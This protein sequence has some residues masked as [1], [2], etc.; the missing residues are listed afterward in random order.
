MIKLRNV[1]LL[2]LL[3]DPTGWEAI[4]RGF[5]NY[6]AY[7]QQ[8]KPVLEK[9][10]LKPLSEG[11]I[12]VALSRL[13]KEIQQYPD[14]YPQVVIDDVVVRS[15]L[16]VLTFYQHP[17]LGQQL[18]QIAAKLEIN[19]SGFFVQTQGVSQ[20]A[21]IASDQVAQQ[22]IDK[23]DQQPFRKDVDQAALTARFSEGYLT[24]PNVLFSLL[25]KLATRRINI[26]E[27]VSTAT[28]ITVI[29]DQQ[30]LDEATDA[31]QEVLK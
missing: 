1:L 15:G 24:I 26:T 31:W 12:V 13:E 11:S 29:I 9:A 19:P 4:C 21:V 30:Y 7:A 17:G 28:E 20:V 5:M 3:N 6:S 22:I 10:A 8:M 25:S 23:I 16:T 18:S 2:T 27:I 14:L